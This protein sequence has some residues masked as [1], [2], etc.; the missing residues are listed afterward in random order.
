VRVSTALDGLAV[1]AVAGTHA[2]LL[3]FDL[4]DP[5]G[6]LGFGIHR[7]DHTEGEGYW[8]R[9]MKTFASLVP[10]P[11]PGMDFS[12]RDHPVQGFQWGDYTAK[13]EHDYTYR[14]LAW[15]GTPG[16]L[17]PL[18]EAAVR[19]TTEAEDDGLH[20]IWF[21]RGVAGSQAFVKRFGQYTPPIG[22][23]EEHPAFA[24][25]SRGLGE[26]FLSTV[27]RG[28]DS[29]WGLRGAFY[30]FTWARGLTALADA[31]A[32]GADVALV[33]HGRDK[34]AADAV[35]NS[36]R[37]AEDN[38][39]AVTAAGL[40]PLVTWRTVANKSALQHNK[41][42][43][44]THD[45]APVAVC[46]GSTNLTQGAIYGHLNVGHLIHDP[47]VAGQFLDYWS[48]LADQTNT[49]ARMRTWTGDHNPVELT[50]APAPGTTATVFSPRATTSGLLSWYADQFDAA[51]SSAHITGA[52]GLHH[53]FRDRL[54]VDRDTV[55]TVLLDQRP[56]ADQLHALRTDPDVR[57]SWGDY[58]RHPDLEGWA[59]EHLTGFNTWVKF[60]HTKIILIDPLTTTP[61]ILTGS[62]NYSDNSTTD[63][64]ENTL[65]IR[66]DGTTAAQRVAD[67]YLT[68]YQRLFMHFVYRDWATPQAHPN[69]NSSA[70]IGAGH[71][72]E[73]DTWAASYYEPGGWRERQ[74]RTFAATDS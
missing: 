74:R 59:G 52:F 67:I 69:P 49:T 71:L 15:G 20:G 28:T 2:V 42:L 12:L 22:A 13:P 32:R 44:L 36:D 43:V 23:S 33:V 5:A 37:T 41:F 4:T 58:L 62:A 30:E 38:R 14:V 6:C 48:A 60:I 55:R 34:D 39:T 54:A 29:T 70:T 24:W 40:D 73:D 8:L 11:A 31:D 50:Q 56:P 17:A 35:T 26:A 10:H 21:N 68:E 18:A 1:H 47:G 46:T 64:E 7:T 61:T 9:G 63:N 19:V 72:S 66:G 25:L 3:G 51:V 27:A 53:V 65:L 57:T 45:G 16:A